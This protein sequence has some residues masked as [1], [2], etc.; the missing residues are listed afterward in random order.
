MEKL[1]NK[2]LELMRLLWDAGEPLSRKGILDRAEGKKFSWSPNSLH[3]IING[4]LKK[5]AIRVAGIAQDS[6]SLGRTYEPTITQQEYALT[7]G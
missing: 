6:R 3:I 4:L 7:Q 1:T 2:E 5:Q